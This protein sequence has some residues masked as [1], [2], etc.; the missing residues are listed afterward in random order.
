MGQIS[1]RIIEI[2][3]T[4][5]GKTESKLRPNWAEWLDAL[6]KQA[7]N[8]TDWKPGESYCI[9]ALCCIMLVAFKEAGK[10]CPIPFSK[11]TQA[12]YNG[13][14]KLGLCS[15]A[16]GVGDIVIFEIG[17]T[18]SG[19]AEL[20]TGVSLEGITTIGFNTGGTISGSQHNG[21]GV[22]AK[23]RRFKDFQKT[24]KPRLWIRGYV[25]LSQY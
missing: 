1:Q 18:A 13:A 23:F 3:T 4:Y 22:Y 9:H 25:S 21:D 7:G 8:P 14:M 6:T 5:L 10:K 2:A 17:D 20:I 15:Q 24:D 12:F 16:P 19:H 11:G